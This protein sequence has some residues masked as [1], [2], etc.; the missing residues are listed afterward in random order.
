MTDCQPAS[1]PGQ[2]LKQLKAVDGTAE[3][4]SN[5]E[6]DFPYIETVGA[7]LFLANGTRPD[8]SAHVNNLACYNKSFGDEHVNAIKDVI[9]YIKGTNDFRLLLK[10]ATKNHVNLYTDADWAGDTNNRKSVSGS[11][12][13]IDETL[14]S[15][16]SKKQAVVALSS[17]E[18]EYISLAYGLQDAIWT[19][20]ISGELMN[21]SKDLNIYVDNQAAIEISK[22]ANKHSRAKHIDIKYHFIHDKLMKQEATLNYCPT[23]EMIA[24]ILTKALKKKQFQ[25]LCYKLGLRTSAALS[26]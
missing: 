10:P 5:K 21:T 19:E 9:R 15:W 23:S 12:V 6:E 13:F 18:A 4:G 14:I 22:Q 16:S 25:R 7:L 2:N 24:G 3:S 11:T 17:M 26:C 20:N 8:M 1:T